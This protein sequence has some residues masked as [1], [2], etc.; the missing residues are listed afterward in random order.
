MEKILR[1]DGTH[2]FR[3]TWK[4]AHKPGVRPQFAIEGIAR[5]GVGTKG[6]FEA[7]VGQNLS[8]LPRSLQNV[9]TKK[10]FTH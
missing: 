10:V 3:L 5:G 4:N 8:K 9:I 1:R 6:R 2:R 7:F